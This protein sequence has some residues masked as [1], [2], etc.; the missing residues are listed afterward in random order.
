MSETRVVVVGAGLAGLSCARQLQSAGVE[1]VVL[2]ASDDIGG[3]VR[4][5]EVDGFLLDRGF[6]VLLT[7]YP[8]CRRQ[9]D[10]DS[11]ALQGFYPGAQIRLGDGFHT[12][13]DP[14][15]RPLAGLLGALAPIGSWRD[16]LRVARLRRRLLGSDLEVVFSRPEM[17]TLQALVEE[18]FSS[19]MVDRFFRPFLGGIFLE[20]EL[21]TSSR[22]FEFVYKMFSSGATALPAAGM[23][24]IPRQL[25]EALAAPAIRMKTR[26]EEIRAGR[27]RVDSGEWVE[28]DAVVVASALPEGPEPPTGMT[29]T[30][31]CSTVC[32]YFSAPESPLSRPILVLNGDG[33][34]PVNNL[35]VPSQ[36]ASTYA[37]ADRELISASV[38]GGTVSEAMSDRDL[39]TTVRV[40]LREWFGAV[41]DSWE[42]LKL[43]RVRHALPRQ[44]PPCLEP[45]QR[46]VALE[47]RLY[48]CG[49]H[50]DNASIHGAMVSGR[51]AAAAVLADL[52]DAVRL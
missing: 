7:A 48:V 21:E 9:L 23:Q 20:R 30:S 4:T 25:A 47:P 36:V 16:K 49:D 12:V 22:M 35:C 28:G 10:Y 37:P 45:P 11:L 41:V 33:K 39:E 40:Q 44:A 19:S 17:T 2:E 18:G 14:W 51:R 13:A 24:A 8:E 3:R 50:R 29:T 32:L 26:V 52:P 46:P 27:V 42:L 43:Y 15:R 1:V 31:W 34:G 38:I 5:D 6:Q